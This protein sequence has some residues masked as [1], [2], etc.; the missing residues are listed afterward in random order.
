M[1]LLVEVGGL[2]FDFVLAVA[3]PS[4]FVVAEAE[5]CKNL[6]QLQPKLEGAVQK[7]MRINLKYCEDNKENS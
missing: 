5:K 3:F 4:P 1:S 2:H 7:P 6:I